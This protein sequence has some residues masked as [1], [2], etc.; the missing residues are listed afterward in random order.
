MKRRLDQMVCTTDVRWWGQLVRQV[1]L[2]WRLLRDGR[3]SWWVKALLVAA[4][5]YIV[6]PFDILPD[7]MPVLGQVDD[8]LVLWLAWKVFLA[9][10]PASVVREHASQ[11]AGEGK[12]DASA[13]LAKQG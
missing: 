3:V 10:C 2:G 13:L 6:L 7:A 8:L 11:L 9:L 12:A 4:V 1:R 5:V